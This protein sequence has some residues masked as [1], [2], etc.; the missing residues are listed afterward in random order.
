[1]PRGSPPAKSVRRELEVLLDALDPVGRP[2]TARFEEAQPQGRMSLEYAGDAQA[3]HRGHLL[4]GMADHMRA[5]V[6]ALAT[7]ADGVD[8]A[9][10]RLVQHDRYVEGRGRGPQRLERLIVDGAAG[11]AIRADHAPDES[12]LLD[13]TLEFRH[14]EARVL[15]R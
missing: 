13:P 2:T 14:R 9:E 6:R 3:Q 1:M 11:D 15:L 12:E 4:E 10:V 8:A 5:R 7:F